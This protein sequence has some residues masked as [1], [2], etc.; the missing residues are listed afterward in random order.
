MC[1]GTGREAKDVGKS[2]RGGA[3]CVCPLSRAR[4]VRKVSAC[5]GD[6][7]SETDSSLVLILF[8]LERLPALAHFCEYS[9][10]RSACAGVTSLIDPECF[11]ASH[12]YWRLSGV[13]QQ[14]VGVCPHHCRTENP[15]PHTPEVQWGGRLTA[16]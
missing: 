12:G 14:S 13:F 1:L 9:S 10:L 15:G 8:A 7:V 11:A 3:R 2:T 6:G 5:D 4:G 16:S